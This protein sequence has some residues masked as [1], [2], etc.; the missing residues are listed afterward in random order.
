MNAKTLFCKAQRRF[1][2][3]RLNTTAA[4]HLAENILEAYGQGESLVLTLYGLRK[5]F[6]ITF[7]LLTNLTQH[8]VVGKIQEKSS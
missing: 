7:H 6:D 8:E 4:I 3:R 5:V 1:R 2:K